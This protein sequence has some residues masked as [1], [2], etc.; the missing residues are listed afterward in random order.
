VKILLI[1]SNF[2]CK[3]TNVLK[4]IKSATNKRHTIENF[5]NF[6]RRSP[7]NKKN[8]EK[9][10]KNTDFA[11][12]IINTCKL[13]IPKTQKSQSP[14]FQTAKHFNALWEMPAF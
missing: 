13:L 8:L 12:N 3:N 11:K 2:F 1:K 7:K 4:A 6:V 10:P 5:E 14:H 9:L